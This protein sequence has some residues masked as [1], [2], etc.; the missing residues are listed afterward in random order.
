[1][2][3]LKEFAVQEGLKIITIKD[4]IAYRLKEESL[5]ERGEEV[6]MPTEYGDFRPHSFPPEK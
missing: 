3:Q 5:I 1:M 4:L 6:S 2:P